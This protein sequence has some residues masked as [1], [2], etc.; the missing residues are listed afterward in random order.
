MKKELKR[1]SGIKEVSQ[2]YNLSIYTIRYYEKIGLYK[3]PRNENGVRVFDED[4]SMRINVIVYYR[5]AGLS[6]KQI[7]HIFRTPTQDK[8]HIKIFLQTKEKLLKQFDD[9]KKTINF[10]DYKI[11]YHKKELSKKTSRETDAN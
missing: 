10:L 8:E 1:G 7:Q 3:V 2:K 6:I 9:L 4:T 5:R 11:S